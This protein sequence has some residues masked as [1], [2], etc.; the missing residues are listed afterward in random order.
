MLLR[1]AS[2]RVAEAINRAGFAVFSRLTV[3]GRENLPRRGG[4]VVVSNHLRMS[5]I[6]LLAASVPRKLVFVGKKQLWDKLAFRTLGNWYDCFSIDRATVDTKALRRSLKVLK[7][8]GAL[9][10]F[11]E[12]TRSLDGRLQQ[13]HPGAA[14]IAMH[15]D[16]PIL[17]VAVTGTD[18]AD[19]ATWLW[20]RPR[21]TITIGKPFLLH[22][23]P[24]NSGKER[25]TPAT[26]LIMRKIA[27]LLPPE[28]K[29]EYGGLE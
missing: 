28:R 27:E 11:P 19:G 5:D 2:W 10:I 9:L 23:T 24:G 1:K 18:K 12:G 26:D 8:G 20:R 25:L 17:P 4:L 15:A 16:V 7:D 13:G 14:L 3:T 22:G 21:L 29:G 6:P